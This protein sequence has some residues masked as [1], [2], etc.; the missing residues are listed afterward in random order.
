ME[1]NKNLRN[2]DIALVDGLTVDRINCLIIIM[3]CNIS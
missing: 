1:K 2:S 3:D